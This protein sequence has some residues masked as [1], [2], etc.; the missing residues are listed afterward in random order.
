MESL[1]VVL[2]LLVLLNS[3]LRLTFVKW[4][5][6]LLYAIVVALFIGST[7]QL[8]TLQ[9]KTQWLEWLYATETLQD[10]SVLV[11]FEALLHI[12]YVFAHLQSILGTPIQKW[13]AKLIEY[14]PPL[15]LFPALFYI[16]TQLFFHLTGTDFS[17]IAYSTIG[18][19]LVLI[20]LLT[21]LLKYLFPEEELR[22]EL[23]FIFNLFV[24]ITGFIA[25]ASAE[26]V[27]SPQHLEHPDIRALLIGLC[28]F[29]SL[30][31]IGYSIGKYRQNKK[32]N[33]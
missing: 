19:V 2:I 15:L 31:I 16:L 9:S 5:H 18:G 7:W 3:L 21:Q 25:T 13:Y 23:S 27:Y 22:L 11:T 8:G 24:C 26:T 1:F 17:L 30:F 4:W 12:S 28:L 20:P 6:S 33:I 14:Y 29:S 10:L 32:V